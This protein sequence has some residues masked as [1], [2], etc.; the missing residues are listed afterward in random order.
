MK[1]IKENNNPL[2]DRTEI[3]AEF[4]SEG[5]TPSRQTILTEMQEKYSKNLVI[6]KINQAFGSKKAIVEARAYK[7]EP[8]LHKYE[9]NYRF[10][11]SEPKE[12]KAK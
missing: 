1:I 8:D 10:K 3:T 12:K 6:I 7:N 5:G 4:D 9:P 11:R 2:F